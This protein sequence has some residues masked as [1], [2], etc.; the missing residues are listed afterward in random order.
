MHKYFI[1]PFLLL[2][3]FLYHI[4]A[5]LAEKSFQKT[6][7][8]G[9]ICLDNPLG[10]VSTPQ[11]LIGVIIKGALGIVGSLALIIV[12]YGGFTWMTAGGSS[13]R[14]QKARDTIVQAALGLIIIFSAYA[15][16]KFIFDALGGKN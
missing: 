2:F 10:N 16:L 5:V 4:N 8:E 13:E 11:D 3:I 12:I 9:A 1:L 7:P 15:I 6:C 14:W